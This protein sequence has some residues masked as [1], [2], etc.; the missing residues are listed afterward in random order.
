MNYSHD[1]LLHKVCVQFKAFAQVPDPDVGQLI[2]LAIEQRQR[3]S[4]LWPRSSSQPHHAAP[5]SARGQTENARTAKRL[6]SRTA[7]RGRC[8]ALWCP[9][10]RS[11]GCHGDWRNRGRSGDERR[12][13]T[14]TNNTNTTTTTTTAATR[15]E[16]ATNGDFT[17]RHHCDTARAVSRSQEIGG[18]SGSRGSGGGDGERG[19][20]L[21]MLLLN[22]RGGRRSVWTSLRACRGFWSGRHLCWTPNTLLLNTG[23]SWRGSSFHLW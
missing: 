21:L 1:I 7:I 11:R 16:K 13:S 22:R 6:S 14:S 19:R 9:Y 12:R 10:G 20:R 4:S 2:H 18:H 5:W 23:R 17:R 15:R 8:G 3:S